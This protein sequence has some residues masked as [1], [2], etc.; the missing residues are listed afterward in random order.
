MVSLV[1]QMQV[2]IGE[3]WRV[4]VRVFRLIA[5]LVRERDR[6]TITEKLR[7]AGKYRFEEPVGVHALHG[8]ESAI[9]LDGDRQRLRLKGAN[10]QP[11][12]LFRRQRVHSQ[13]VKWRAVIT[14]RNCRHQMAKLNLQVALLFL[15]FLPFQFAFFFAG[16]S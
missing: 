4:A 16:L 6:K 14:A 7:L 5:P 12:R 15:I 10:H 8:M 9:P 11:R 1:E 2:V 13:D 3:N